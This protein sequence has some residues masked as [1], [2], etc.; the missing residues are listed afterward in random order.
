[1]SDYF[2]LGIDFG[3]KKT[4]IA[5]GQMITKKS[6]PLKIIYDNYLEEITLITNE[7]NIKKII[8]GFPASDT[9]RE[10]KIQTE[11]RCFSNELKKIIDPNIEIILFDESS[12]SDMAKESFKEMRVKGVTKKKNSNYDDISASIILQSWINENTME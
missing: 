6:R 1:M 9:K 11:I 2:Y 8:V 5:I 12:S 3:I 4:G 7:W 10:N